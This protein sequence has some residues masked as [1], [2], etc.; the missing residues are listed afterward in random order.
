MFQQANTNP[1]QGSLS[2]GFTIPFSAVSVDRAN[3]P[4][5]LQ[6]GWHGNSF[7]SQF[8]IKRP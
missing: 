3:R 4:S 5:S 1:L 8:V 6:A 7:A 2:P